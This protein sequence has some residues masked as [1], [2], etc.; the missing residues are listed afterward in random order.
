VPADTASSLD[1]DRAGSTGGVRA[2]SSITPRR[3][4]TYTP[5]P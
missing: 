3:Y 1:R 2:G 4:A 5:A